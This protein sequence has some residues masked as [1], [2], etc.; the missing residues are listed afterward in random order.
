MGHSQTQKKKNH[1]RIVRTASKR[2]REKG[3]EGVGIADLMQEIGLTVGG[4]YKHFD[5]RD[6][7]V[8]EALRYALSTRRSQAASAASG[9]PP[10]TY[11]KLVE[12]YLSEEHRDHPGSG[13]VISALAGDIARSGKRT[14]AVLTEEIRNALQLIADLTP[15]KVEEPT[16]STAILTLSALVGAV[17]LARA[18][19]DE[20]L[21]REILQ[22]VGELLKRE[23]GESGDVHNK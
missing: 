16:R 2:F 17:G 13:C 14:R 22:S 20:A 7:L 18:V 21:S 6:D 15:G 23:L 4:F 8:V 5:S 19:S 12:D 10:L 9:G 3:L 11:A 1:E